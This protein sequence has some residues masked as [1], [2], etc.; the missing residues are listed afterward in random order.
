MLVVGVDF[1]EAVF[2][3]GGEVEGVSGSE[4]DG[5]RGAEEDGFYSLN[6]VFGEGKQADLAGGTVRLKLDEDGSD[7]SGDDEG[8]AYFAMAYGVKFGSAVQCANEFVCGDRTG[9]DF[10]RARLRPMQ[11]AKVGGIKITPDHRASRSSERPM[12]ES[13]VLTR[14]PDLSA[15]SYSGWSFRL[16]QLLLTGIVASAASA[17]SMR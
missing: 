2:G 15:A 14:A 9:G 3:G 16:A 12:V 13:T 5:G 7:G 17:D 11:F 6:D 8:F 10:R 1:G 4:V